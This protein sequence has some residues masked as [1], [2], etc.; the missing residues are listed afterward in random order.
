MAAVGDVKMGLAG[1]SPQALEIT[2]TDAAGS[3]PTRNSRS[4]SR[5]RRSRSRPGPARG[6][7]RPR[8]PTRRSGRRARRGRLRLGSNKDACTEL[9]KRISAGL[10]DAA[11]KQL[12]C[13]VYAPAVSLRATPVE[14]AFLERLLGD[15]APAAVT[16]AVRQAARRLRRPDGG[17]RGADRVHRPALRL[18]I[19]GPVLPSG[20][21]SRPA[22]RSPHRPPFT[23]VAGFNRRCAFPAA[24]RGLDGIADGV[25]YALY[26]AIA[27]NEER[28]GAHLKTEHRP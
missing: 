20:A 11:R 28:R 19:R 17:G 2:W 27:A 15:D 7:P 14:L 10:T 1:G 25:T 12:L 13:I 3:T 16:D 8:R 26:A 24:L 21:V 4:A 5:R 9:G 23:A 6:P 22:S 18:V